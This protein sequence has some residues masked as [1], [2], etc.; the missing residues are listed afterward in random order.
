MTAPPATTM[1]NAARMRVG[2]PKTGV[3]P[4]YTYLRIDYLAHRRMHFAKTKGQD[5]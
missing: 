1:N 5:K 3:A 2:K 4:D